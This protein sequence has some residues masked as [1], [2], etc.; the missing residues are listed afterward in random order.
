MTH[1]T[2]PYAHRLGILRDWKSK[3]FPKSKKSLRENLKMDTAIRDFVAKRLRSYYIGDLIIERNANDI[4]R[5]IIKTSRPG[6]VIGRSGEE[7]KKITEELKKTLKRKLK[8][9]KLPEF[10]IDVE[11]IK[12]PETN[13]RIV[14]L[15]V[16]EALE[17]RMPFKRVMKSTVEKVMA[18]R[19]VQGVRVRISGR[20]NGADMART[21]EIRKGRVPLQT[22]RADIDFARERAMI[23]QGVLGIKIWIYKGDV[24][25]KK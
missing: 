1:T 24:L 14:A 2:H 23:P 5:V 8:M 13:A 3:W 9:P 17:K 16:A 19:D 18:N 22:F 12:N 15:M 7:L 4:V 20:L 21:E 10:R 11:E 6:L 25:E